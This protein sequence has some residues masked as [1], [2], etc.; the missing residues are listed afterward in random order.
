MQMITMTLGLYETNCYLLYD[1]AT[2]H[3][4][5]IDPGYEPERLLGA[6]QAHGL[7]LQAILITHA[8]FD[9]VGA[10]QPL[11]EATGC[12]IYV[13]PLDLSM[14]PYLRRGLV[15]TDFYEEGDH[16][17]FDSLHFQV[18]HT[19]GH[20]KG[21]ICLMSER[22][23]VC[24]TGDTVFNVDLGRTDLNDGSYEEMVD[25]ILRVVNTWDN[26]ITIY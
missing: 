23:R 6:L 19:P 22:D 20:T 21:G 18:L 9:H 8:H 7:S 24:F 11:F 13:H 5:L 10:T 17:D 14:P 2:R 4:V 15:N 16:L 25:S 26:D 12:R 1:E 3:A